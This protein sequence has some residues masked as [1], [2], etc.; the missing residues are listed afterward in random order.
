MSTAPESLELL[1]RGSDVTRHREGTASTQR[2]SAAKVPDPS[3]RPDSSGRP[4]T[5]NT[6]HRLRNSIMTLLPSRLHP[7]GVDS[8]NVTSP[9]RICRKQRYARHGLIEL[10][11]ILDYVRLSTACCI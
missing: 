11:D 10:T 1:Q 2:K 4:P 5:P 8:T 6:S 9:E 7:E 3:P